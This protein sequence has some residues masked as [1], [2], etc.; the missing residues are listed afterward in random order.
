MLDGGLADFRSLKAHARAFLEL[1]P[2][3]TTAIA[4]AL[5]AGAVLLIPASKQPHMTARTSRLATALSATV[6][7]AVLISIPA[8]ATYAKREVYAAITR[9][10]P[11]TA[12]P[13]WLEAPS[14]AD[15]VRIH[16]VSAKTL[17]DVARAVSSDPAADAAKVQLALAGA[18][19]SSRSAKPSPMPSRR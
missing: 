7:M 14:R 10:T 1:D 13:S 5:L 16:G 8:L 2:L 9:G 6:A 19:A 12:L 18:G 11:L 15:L 3:N 17:E 4:V